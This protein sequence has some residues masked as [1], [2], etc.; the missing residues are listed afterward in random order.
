ML[1]NV[2][3]VTAINTKKTDMVKWLLANGANSALLTSQ[4][5]KMVDEWGNDELNAMIK[6]D[7]KQ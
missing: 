2:G 6:N 1:L 4:S 5:L 3:V 7:R